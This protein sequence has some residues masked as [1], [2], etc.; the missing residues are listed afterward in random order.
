[1]AQFMTEAM[2]LTFLGAIVGIGLAVAAGAPLTQFLV[3]SSNNTGASMV[4]G[5]G[6]ARFAGAGG[7]ALRGLRGSISNI[8]AVV[9][10]D[11]ILY[12]LGAALLIAVLGSA[13]ASFFI[14]KIRPAEVMRAE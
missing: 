9:G 7:I 4:T 14:A 6:F 3:T 5:G 13:L 1:M 11:I 8:N 12:G 2:T 10:W